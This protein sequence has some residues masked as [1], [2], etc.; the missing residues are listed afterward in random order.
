M[1][2]DGVTT[3]S[4][5]TSAQ[6]AVSTETQEPQGQPD[7]GAGPSLLGREDELGGSDDDANKKD[8][9]ETGSD[10]DKEADPA[11]LVPAK[12]EDYQITFGKDVTVDEMLLSGFKNAAHE[13]G[14]PQGQAQKLADFYTKHMAESSKVYQDAQ[15]A[16]LQTAKKGW[17]TEIQSRPGFK[18][19][20]A[21]AKRALSPTT[22]FGSKELVEVLDQTLIGSHPAFFDFM[23]KVGKALAEPEVKGNGTGGKDEK[24]LE[25][26]MWPNMETGTI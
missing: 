24:P 18:Q 6:D 7:H 26:R 10:K 22:G 20:V 8:E 3:D 1:S 2:E 16:A 11:T 17:E 21:D 12:P 5:E 23:A 9:Q 4:V 25:Y 19:E 15:L 13:M 14:I